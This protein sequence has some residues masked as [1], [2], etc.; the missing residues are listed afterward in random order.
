MK[1]AFE[2]TKTSVVPVELARGVMFRV[3]STRLYAVSEDN[4]EVKKAVEVVRR[5]TSK[6]QVE[7]EAFDMLLN[8]FRS[9]FVCLA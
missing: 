1:G 7:P 4:D 9:R 3:A 6:T 2:V 5:S 8:G